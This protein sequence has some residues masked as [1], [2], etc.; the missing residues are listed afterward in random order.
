MSLPTVQAI[1]ILA[2]PSGTRLV[3]GAGGLGRDVSWPVTLRTRAPGFPFLKGGEFLLIASTTIALLDPALSLV[4]L[5]QS[6]A[7]VGV[8]GAAVL[9]DVSSDCGRWADEHSLPVFSLPVGTNLAELESTIARTIADRRSEFDRRAHDLYRQLAQLAIEERGIAA[10]VEELA[11]VTGK[12]ALLLDSGMSPREVHRSTGAEVPLALLTR[13]APEVQVWTSRVPASAT[14]PPLRLFPIDDAR[15]ILIAPV[16]TREGVAGYIAV[17]ARPAEVDALDEASVAG[18]AAA[19][20]IDLARERAVIEAEE[21]A[22][23]S[24][25]EDLLAGSTPLSESLRRRAARLDVDLSREH[26]VLITIIPPRAGT[27]G[28]LDVYAREARAALGEVQSGLIAGNLTTIATR[29]DR[30]L[31]AAAESLREFLVRRT[32]DTT[33]STGAGRHLPGLDGLR[34]S[35]REANEALHLG[36]DIYGAGRTILYADLGLYRLLLTFQEHPELGRFYRDTMGKLAAYDAKSEGELLR[37]LDAYFAANCSPTEAATRLHV[38]RNTL[39]Y[40]L[41]RIRT[42]ADIDLDDPEVR[43]SLQIALRI[44]RILDNSPERRR[45][46]EEV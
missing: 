5:L 28:F 45:M 38:H 14:E 31:Q 4:R 6:V 13:L 11:R 39:L 18:A 17:V 40:R 35:Y 44:R 2:L 37:T 26:S 19:G 30:A 34:Q 1:H 29:S 32:G 27:T 21:R 23:S 42:V 36:R 22:Q 7:R 15:S 41:Q 43:L 25:I 9:G 24:A 20:A 12:P 46:V 16:M 10:I 33:I 8:A 3:A